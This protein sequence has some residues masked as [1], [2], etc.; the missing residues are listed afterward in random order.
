MSWYKTA[1]YKEAKVGKDWLEILKVPEENI[2]TLIEFFE[3]I[4]ENVGPTLVNK[5]IKGNPQITVEDLQRQYIENFAKDTQFSKI[6]PEVQEQINQTSQDKDEREW[7]AKI[8]NEGS[9]KPHDLPM[10]KDTLKEL[11]KVSQKKA[12]DFKNFEELAMFVS[13]FKTEETQ[14]SIEGLPEDSYKLLDTLDGVELFF[15]NTDTPNGQKAIDTLA[16]GAQWCVLT[17]NEKVYHDPNE[18]YLFMV[19]G[20]PEA[21]AHPQSDQIKNFYDAPLKDPKLVRRIHPLVEKHN[22]YSP[23]NSEDYPE[24]SKDYKAYSE[25]LEAVRGLEEIEQRADDE[26]FINNILDE[27]FTKLSSVPKNKWGKY[28]LKFWEIFKRD[29]EDREGNLRGY[30]NLITDLDHNLLKYLVDD[31]IINNREEGIYFLKVAANEWMNSDD[32]NLTIGRYQKMIPKSLRTIVNEQFQAIREAAMSRWKEKLEK[33]DKPKDYSWCPFAELKN[34]PQIIDKFGKIWADFIKEKTSNGAS[35]GEGAFDECPE[36]LRNHPDVIQASHPYYVKGI[37]DIRNYRDHNS[38]YYETQVPEILKNDP[39]IL[40]ERKMSH[41]RMINNTKAK[42][43]TDRSGNVVNDPFYQVPEDLKEDSDVYNQIFKTVEGFFMNATAFAEQVLLKNSERVPL[44][45]ED[46][47]RAR[48]EGW[49]IY[50]KDSLPLYL[51]PYGDSGYSLGQVIKNPP[52]DLKDSVIKEALIEGAKEAVRL[53]YQNG[54]LD[55]DALW[56]LKE[57]YPLALG[58]IKNLLDTGIAVLDEDN[59][60]ALKEELEKIA[61][62]RLNSSAFNDNYIGK[63]S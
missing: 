14:G 22:L 56:V 35:A 16:E 49:Y 50:A 24:K 45:E 62:A 23:E 43:L 47:A 18:Y 10:I 63:L 34:D 38:N 19:D 13:Q 33:G 9:I 11:R 29:W 44:K 17:K 3:S 57:E 20:R 1:L 37:Q 53:R 36:E 60:I 6:S 46:F 8:I 54:V 28:V 27:D 5:F 40:E 52:E 21:L 58:P 61:S 55:A 2:P 48:R 12:S 51:G 39:Q 42:D 31:A 15:I 59:G 41:I 25:M 30:F 26:D 4:P 32:E 7:L